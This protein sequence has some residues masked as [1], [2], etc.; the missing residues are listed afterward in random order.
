ME[1]TKHV[2]LFEAWQANE[3]VIGQP[4]QLP[5]KISGEYR[6][7][8]GVPNVG[9]ALHSFNR[10]KSDGF[11]GYMLAGNPPSRWS[12]AIVFNQGKS[13]NQAL[14]EVWKMGINP[15]ITDLKV[16]VDS[17]NYQVKWEATI[18]QSRDGKAYVGVSSVGSAGGGADTRAQGQI[19]AMK[20]W[21]RGA[22]DWTLVLDFKNPKGIYIRQFF[23]KF[24]KPD[25]HPPYNGMQALK[26]TPN[27]IM[28]PGEYKLSIGSNWTY[29]LTKDGEWFAK[30]NNAQYFR[31]KDKLTP[32]DYSKAVDN[33]KGATKV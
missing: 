24:T 8:K 27:T 10:R 20:G 12:S 9:D 16:E 23:Y 4:I 25:T 18:D 32:A 33:L 14:E 2:K 3:G 31:L 17:K 5:M 7:P 30:L 1:K 13:I 19:E 15:D 6:V 29:Q 11:G 22:R 21:N 28:S 26:S